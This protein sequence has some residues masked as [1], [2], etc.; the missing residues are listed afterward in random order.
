MLLYAVG[1]VVWLWNHLR[2]TDPRPKPRGKRGAL[3]GALRGAQSSLRTSLGRG[4]RASLA[5]GRQRTNKTGRDI[6]ELC[7][8]AAFFIVY[9]VYPSCSA[10]IFQFFICDTF[11]GPGEDGS[12]WMRVDL[13]IDC[14]SDACARTAT[15]NVNVSN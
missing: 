2:G 12:R 4:I 14:G 15:R 10:A 5:D 7:A 9:L 8:T 11:D 3:R 1:P 13:S 6:S